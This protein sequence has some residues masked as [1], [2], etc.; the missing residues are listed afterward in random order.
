VDQHALDL[1]R[2]SVKRFNEY[3]ACL[4]SAVDLESADLAG[5]NLRNADLAGADLRAADLSGADL[6]GANLK[7]ASLYRARASG[8][9]LSRCRLDDAYLAEADLADADLTQVR[10]T[11]ANLSRAVLRRARLDHA[12]FI[13]AKL[14]GADLQ[15]AS[16]RGALLVR[17]PLPKGHNANL[18]DAVIETSHRTPEL[19][20][21][22]FQWIDEDGATFAIG[23]WKP[24]PD[25][26]DDQVPQFVR[27]LRA[28]AKGDPDTLK[29]FAKVV[30]GIVRKHHRLSAVDA[31]ACVPS[32]NP[33]KADDPVKAFAEEVA[34]ATGL[35]DGTGWLFRHKLVLPSGFLSLGGDE[36]KHIDSVKVIHNEVVEGRTILLLDDFIVTGCSFRACR[37]LLLAAGAKQVF[38]LALA[39]RLSSE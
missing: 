34:R 10:A 28:M 15:D 3:K 31:I 16:F 24:Q 22:D 12:R 6:S 37:H 26:P 30:R 1:L 27:K 18:K 25:A 23:A 19:P 36:A 21:V 38:C 20:G 7:E 33:G 2:K 8:A 4:A 9:I 29:E 35:R 13:D 14:D 32:S 17:T 39:R 5:R 11:G